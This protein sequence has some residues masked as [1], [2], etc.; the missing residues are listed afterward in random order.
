[1]AEPKGKKTDSEIQLDV[2]RELKWDPRVE[3]TDVGVEVDNGI[4]TLTGTV[5]SWAKR[6]AAQEAAR[7]VFGVLDVAN[8]IAVKV[9]GTLARTDTDIAQAVRHALQWDVMIPED[10]ITSTVS[11]GWVTLEGAVDYETQHED[12]ERAVRNLTGVGGVVNRIRVVVRAAR[13]EDVRQAIEEALERRAEREARRIHV[14]TSDG[15]VTLTGV[16]RSSGER[17]ALVSA[18]RFTPGVRLV[19][20]HLTVDPYA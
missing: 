19:N 5:T 4:V 1:M 7:R 8:D 10:R 18:A 17:Q 6:V 2:L 20:D 9:P 13:A 11:K 3:E 16:V 12:A 15:T 14:E